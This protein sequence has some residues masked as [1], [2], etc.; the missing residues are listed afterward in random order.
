MTS[1]F[2]RPYA[3]ALLQSVPANFDAARWAA[4]LRDV[5]AAIAGSGVLRAV[6]A[7]PSVKAEAKRGVVEALTARAGA[8][9]LAG[10]FLRLLLDNG[11]I[12]Q[13]GEVLDAIR[14]AVD[15]REGVVA[16]KVAVASEIDAPARERVSAAL[17]QATGRKV[18]ATFSTDPR[19]IAGFVARV[20][21]TV[22]DASA[23]GAIEKFKEEAHGN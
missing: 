11:R 15:A 5:A 23:L 14:D 19:L 16:A 13:L 8:D 3:D 2:A 22:Y 9:P 10:R 18:R 17:S 6:L 12:L 21:S 7:N 1:R 4:P 20:G